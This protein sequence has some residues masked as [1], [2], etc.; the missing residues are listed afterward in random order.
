[1][2]CIHKASL[3]SKAESYA[4][5]GD[6]ESAAQYLMGYVDEFPDKEDLQKKADQYI[7]RLMDS[8]LETA[9]G[10]IKK[11][12]Y[13]NAI[14]AIQDVKKDYP[15]SDRVQA[16]EQSTVDSYLKQQLPLIDA[17]MNSADY[18][19]AYTICNNALELVPDDNELLTR[20][21][22]IDAKRPILL[23]ELP[24]SQSSKFYRMEK[25][26]EIWWDT[27]HNEYTYGNLYYIE[28]WYGEGYADIYLG[29]QYSS[30]SGVIA[31]GNGSDNTSGKVLIY[32]DGTLLYSG[33][34][35][36]TTVPQKIN[37]DVSGISW[38]KIVGSGNYHFDKMDYL[39]SDFAFMKLDS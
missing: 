26:G 29:S 19:K 33:S 7:D 8:L 4:E 31:V 21:E 25:K 12:D 36:R 34:Y 5:N 37:L 30:L 24:I 11:G 35:S 15:D 32:G 20:M 17:A 13:H 10:Y 28:A 14:L 2:R 23:N 16:L 39:F 3:F 22:T 1:M 9:N 27:I 38:L 6:Y 18:L